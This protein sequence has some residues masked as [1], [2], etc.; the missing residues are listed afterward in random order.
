M[1][2][3]RVPGSLLKH[4]LDGAYYDPS[5]LALDARL[6]QLGNARPLESLRDAERPITNGVRGPEFVDSTFKLIRLQDCIE[7]EV[8]ADL[9]LSISIKQF[10][11]NARCRL[12]RD[13]VVVAIGGYVG[14]AAVVIDDAAAVIGQHS[15]RVSLAASGPMDSR[16]LVAY[17]NAEPG[18]VQ[19]ARLMRGTVQQGLNLEDVQEIEVPVFVPLAQRY[20]ADK[21][22]QAE[23]LRERARR[24]EA[25]FRN[26]VTIAIPPSSSMAAKTSRVGT[27]E[28]GRNLN[29]GAYTPDRRAVRTAIRAVGGRPLDTLADVESPTTDSYSASAPY[30]GLDAIDSA[31]CGLKPSTAAAESVAGTSR[32]LREGPALSRLRPYLNKVAYI[33]PTLAG[34]IGSTELLLVRPKTG[35]DGWFLYGVLKLESSIRQL[36]PVATGSTHPRVDR[37]DVLD[38]LVPWRDE[39]ENLGGKLRTAQACYFGSA[40]LTLTATTLVEHLIDGRLKEAD[41]VAAQRALEA[42]EPGADREILKSL[43]RSAEPSAMPLIADVDALYALLK[44]EDQDA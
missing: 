1:R 38:L 12:R 33:P 37:E 41:L 44:S 29:P 2:L 26:A 13:D 28:L 3:A 32:L 9:A 18:R 20:I 21:V 23:R 35:V 8:R 27:G 16:F 39:H 15:A 6:R 34:G 22:R 25:E 14:N 30:I 10:N 40:G 5:A 7:W 31:T 11:E 36:N 17:L 24:L 42:G 4:R 19:F 43:R